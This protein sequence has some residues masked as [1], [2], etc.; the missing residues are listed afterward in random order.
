MQEHKLKQIRSHSVELCG[1][2]GDIG[3]AFSLIFLYPFLRRERYASTI[4]CASLVKVTVLCDRGLNSI[5][6]RP[7]SLDHLLCALRS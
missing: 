2:L 6:K 5:G 1:F 3:T 4:A 7:Q